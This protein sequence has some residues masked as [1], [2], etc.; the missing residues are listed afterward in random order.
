MKMR[1]ALAVSLICSC[2]VAWS[3]PANAQAGAGAGTSGQQ[4]T[5]PA[6]QQQSSQPKVMS[7]NVANV[8]PGEVYRRPTEKEKLRSWA[9]VSFGPYAFIGS[10]LAGGAHDGGKA[11]REG[12][13]GSGG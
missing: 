12:G 11:A 9:F 4:Q 13:W 1:L 5:T 3:V 8:Q 10:A 2:I 6:P 7:P